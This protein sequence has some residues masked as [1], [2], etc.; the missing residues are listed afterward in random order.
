MFGGQILRAFEFV[1]MAA[2]TLLLF[3]KG[4]I[5]A[6]VAG[7]V[8]LVISTLDITISSYKFFNNDNDQYSERRD[9]DKLFVSTD[10]YANANFSAS[11]FDTQIKQ[12]NHPITGYLSGDFKRKSV[13]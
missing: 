7:I 4:K 2:L 5:S 9:A 11:P 3:A 1:L 12:T 13:Q 8:L 6:L 10:D